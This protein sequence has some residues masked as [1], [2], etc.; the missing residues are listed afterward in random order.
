MKDKIAWVILAGKN[1]TN[2]K[3]A[4]LYKKFD[5]KKKNVDFFGSDAVEIKNDIERAQSLG[6]GFITYIDD[7][8]P[9]E[10]R[11]I[12]YPPPYLFYR[13]NIGLL[14]HPAKVTIVGSREA[15]M[16]GMNTAF[17]FALELAGEKICIVSGGARGVDAAAVRGALNGGG[18]VIAVIGTGIDVDYPKENAKL[19]ENVAK[20]GVIISEFPLGMGP[21]AQNFPVRN[22]VMTALGDSVV[23]VEAAAK[24]GALISASHAIEQGKTLFAVPGNID[25]LNSIGTNALIRDGALPALS[26]GDILYELMDRIPDKIRQARE[27]SVNEHKKEE[28]KNDVPV[29]SKEKNQTHLSPF[30][31]AVV[32]ALKSGKDTYEEIYEYTSMETS[33]LTS[34]LTIM[35]IKGIIKLASRNRYELTD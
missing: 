24:S 29:K 18:S 32:C 33:K 7:E 9:E 5:S 21:L 12:A 3:M 19:F 30:E 23:I 26:S 22:R 15:T 34:V 28:I 17:T 8:Y 2:K 6:Y 11:H 27:F 10:L 14:K 4:E 1:R 25:S 20:N 31:Q 35:E 13:G 16:Y